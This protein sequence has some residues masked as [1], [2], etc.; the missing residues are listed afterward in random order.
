MSIPSIRTSDGPNGVRGI[1]FFN[2]TPAACLPCATA[3]GATFDVDLLRSVGQ[4]LGQEAKAKG[5]HVLLGPTMNIQRSP[6][7]GRGF[8]SF[9]ADPF[10]SGM[11]GGEYCNGAHQEDIIA[12]PKHYACNDQENERIAVN[13]IVTDR[14]LREIYLMP[15]MLS[16]RTARPAAL[17]TSYNK[18][19]G[20]H[21]SESGEILDIPRREWGWEGLMM[22]DW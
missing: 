1:R 13:S 18:I 5:A 3:L 14:A 21:V 4:L 6:L 20:R 22:S 2:G 11:L 15:F 7:G 16:V 9:S 12:V 10:L 8:E 17:M 19:N